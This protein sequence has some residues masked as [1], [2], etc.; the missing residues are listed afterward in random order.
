[1]TRYG[2]SPWID[3]IVT[4]RV[5]SFPQLR[6]R[7]TSDVAIV[8]GGLTGCA[9]AY[10][11]AAAG[12]KVALVEADRIGRGSSGFSSGWISDDPGVSFTD[13]ESALGLRAARHAW[14][15]WRRAALDF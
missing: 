10:S 9:I 3:T 14:Q 8:G 4:S 7:T 2:K 12:L 15:S 5:T 13:V 11:F 1:M 6:G